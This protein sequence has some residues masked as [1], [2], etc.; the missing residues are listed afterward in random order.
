VARVLKPGGVFVVAFSNRWFPPK[1]IDV[2]KHIHEFERMALVTEYFL[3]DGCF[4]NIHTVSRRGY[5]RP[6]TDKYFPEMKM[7]DPIYVV[8][9]TRV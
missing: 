3:H 6:Y 9:G 8:H 1:A 2:W 7:A 5:P 4:G